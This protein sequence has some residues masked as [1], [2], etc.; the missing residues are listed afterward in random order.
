MRNVL[1]HLNDVF[2]FVLELLA[3]FLWGRYVA[4][5]FQNRFLKIVAVVAVVTVFFIIWGRF[6]SPKATQELPAA[7]YYP[8]KFLILALPALQFLKNNRLY[9]VL[10]IA[11][12]LV[13]LL[14]QGFFGRGEWTL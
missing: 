6:F 12:V 3:L 1:V 9:A 4:S 14:I 10:I 2:A 13:N 8:T 11:G 5:F 7:L